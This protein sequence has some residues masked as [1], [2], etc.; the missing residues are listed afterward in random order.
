MSDDFAILQMVAD[1][2]LLAKDTEWIGTEGKEA[3]RQIGKVMLHRPKKMIQELLVYRQYV[4]TLI[5]VVVAMGDVNRGIR[6]QNER[7]E[8]M[9]A[10][11]SHKRWTPEE[12]ESLIETVC[13]EDTN[14]HEISAIFG[15]SPAAIQR[16][17]THLVGVKRLSQAVAGRFVGTIGGVETDSDISGIV[18][19]EEDGK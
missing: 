13:R 17:I 11:K 8:A 1:G 9:T 15:R 6:M 5:K 3:L 14:I 2:T 4:P 16:R 7:Y 10:E 19:R 12:D 18:Y